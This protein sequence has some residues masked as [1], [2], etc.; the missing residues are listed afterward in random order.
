LLDLPPKEKLRSSDTN[1]AAY[2][3][4]APPELNR[5][6]VCLLPS[7][8]SAG[9]HLSL[10]S[11]FIREAFLCDYHNGHSVPLCSLINCRASRSQKFIEEPKLF[12]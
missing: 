11:G 12:N 5:L 10:V 6:L 3:G 4:V 1:L 9:V 2:E 8:H 7:F